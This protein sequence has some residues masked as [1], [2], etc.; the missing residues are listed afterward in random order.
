MRYASSD[1]RADHRHCGPDLEGK[2]A[3][4][5]ELRGARDRAGAARVREARTERTADRLPAP[6]ERASR[7]QSRRRGRF[8]PI[9]AAPLGKPIWLAKAPA[10]IPDMSA[11]MLIIQRRTVIWY[12]SSRT[13]LG[14]LPICLMTLP[15]F[16]PMC[17][18]AECAALSI[19]FHMSICCMRPSLASTAA[20]IRAGEHSYASVPAL[21]P[22]CSS[23]SQ[24]D[25]DLTLGVGHR[26]RP[27]FELE[28]FYQEP[29][30][31]EAL[32]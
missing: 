1:E 17:C 22:S 19:D 31:L 9:E 20:R 3:G 27:R 18:Q 28:P 7:R 4:A 8:E 32:R 29:T 2:R 16:S 13:A 23:C 5:A 6:G 15:A 25:C 11:P 12:S 30:G 14:G 26:E 24:R 21:M 10:A